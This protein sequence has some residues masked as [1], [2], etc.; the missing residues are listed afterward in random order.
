[1]KLASLRHGRD[2]ALI[3]VSRDGRRFARAHSI[4]PTLQ[5]ALDRWEECETELRKLS[6]RLESGAIEGEPLDV[7]ALSAP[8]PRAYEWVDASAFI[9]HVILVRKARGAEP[10]PKLYTEP[11]VY[12]G[13]SSV[14]L[15]PRDPI[16]LA[17]PA[18]GCD[19]EA[20]IALILGDTPEGTTTKQ[21]Q[22]HIRLILLVNDVTLR[23][24]VPE[25]LAK[26]FGFFLSKP[27]SAFSP[28]AITLDELGEYWRDG[29]VHLPLRSHLNGK[30]IGDPNAGEMHFSFFE[31]IA[32]ITRTRSFGAGTIL[33]SGT[34]S[35]A[36][37]SRGVS[38]LVE[39]RMREILENGQA[40]TPFLQW[41]DEVEIEMQ[42]KDG[43]S[44]FGSI[45][46]R[47]IPRNHDPHQPS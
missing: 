42:T 45:R 26:G 31:L 40:L 28:F 8:L 25:E 35:N 22:R 43:E 3:V 29:R 16:T 32:Y 24:L 33:G 11:L 4:A 21:A 47:V 36:D 38:C 46:Q 37:P 15:G 18:W 10:P 41:G 7:H 27:A 1:M 13:G 20:E 23:N 12:Q 19:F 39:K 14:L 2:G 34:V 17:D 44:L 30:L 6:D 5:S 9:N